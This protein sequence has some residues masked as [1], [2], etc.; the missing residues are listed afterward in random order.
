MSVLEAKPLPPPASAR[1][2]LEEFAAMPGEKHFELVN[3]KLVEKRMGTLSNWVAGELCG[4]IRDHCRNHRLG[5]VFPE[6]GYECF[7]ESPGTVRKPD[8]SFVRFGRLPNERL[9]EPWLTIAP[10]LAVEVISPNDLAGEVEEKVRQY[11]G[12]GVPL[13]WVVYPETRTV[14]VHRAGRGAVADLLE[15]DELSGEEVVPGFRCRV[16]DLFPAAA[17]TPA[18]K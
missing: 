2:T 7:P 5:W 12:A 17:S 14:R 4:R 16:S 11:L 15:K 10:D 13:V 9:P 6:T 8:V 18:P 1:L 3:G